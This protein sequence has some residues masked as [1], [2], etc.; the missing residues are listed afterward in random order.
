MTLSERLYR[1]LLFSYPAE[2]R[3]EYT[4]EMV[5]LFQVRLARENRFLLWLELVADIAV[6]APKEHYYVLLQDLRYALRAFA[7]T[8]VFALTA[9]LTLAL[10]IGANTAIFSVVHAVALRPLPFPES[11]RLVRLWEMNQKL[12]I[13]YFSTSVPNYFSWKEQAQ[14]FEAIGVF[15]FASLNITGVGEPERLQAG[16]LTAS[17]FQ[18]L[19]LRPML[20]RGFLPEEE[21][22]RQS[23]VAI[24]G[25]PLWRRRFAADPQIVGRS[26]ELNGVST[27]IVGVMPPEFQFPQNAEIW[28]PMSINLKYE[29][30]GDHRISAIARLKPGVTLAQADAEMKS[31][32][33]GL[34]KVFP[35]SNQ[36]W[37]VRTA[38]FYD[39]LVPPET[40]TALAVLLGAVGLV[41]LIACSNVANLLLARA[42]GRSR[43][44]AMRITLG[45]GRSRLVRQLLT[46]SMLLALAGGIAGTLLA[47]WAVAALKQVLPPSVPRSSEIG[48]D[49]IVLAFALALS[50]LTG[51]L[52]GL[53]PLWHATRRDINDLLKEGGRG[54]TAS[55]PILRSALVVFEVALGTVLVIG[56]CLLVRSFIHLENV[57]LGFQPDHLLTAQISLPEGKYKDAAA[58]AF[59]EQLQDRLKNTPGIT[60]AA[61]SSGV[62]FGAGDYTGMSTWVPG[63]VDPPPSQQVQADWRMVSPGY[64]KVLGVPLLR[65][66][67]FGKEDANGRPTVIISGSAARRLFGEQNPVGREIQL[68]NKVRFVVVGVVGDIRQNELA[69]EPLPAMYFPSPPSLWAT[70]TV[71]IRTTGDPLNAASLLREKVKELDPNQPLFNVRSMDEWLQRSAAEPRAYTLLLSIFAGV[72]LALA[73]IGVYGVLSYSVA[74]RTSEIGVRMALGARGWHVLRLVLGQGMLL[75]G[76]GLALGLGSALGLIRLIQSMLYG[77]SSHDP[78]TFLGVTAAL[79]V[80]A[81]AACLLPGLR[82]M[83]VDPVIALRTE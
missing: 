18:V 17:V 41:L 12:N 49:R 22:L 50:M 4:P 57:Q 15:G 53:A 42:V 8:P 45:A 72:A 56:A 20:G 66:R 5:E 16:T 31:I 7:K 29:N 47:V 55:R 82:A 21:L 19:R 48:I 83:R 46:E 26:V 67:Q 54:S 25:E 24:I 79:F 70:F 44:I 65:G 81:L 34:E 59:Y 35:E 10:G 28:V 9:I 80:I 11:D 58:S 30:R 13:S 60:G 52:F 71:V 6:S 77:V 37:S 27:K 73:C 43:E 36:G 69:M 78:E 38:K 74:Q 62:P 2:F 61:I 33:A 51:L 14:S 68:S 3:H 75:V 39:W 63:E 76:A 40:R 1:S 64:L 32:A 23:G